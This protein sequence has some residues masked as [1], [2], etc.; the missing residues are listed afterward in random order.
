VIAAWDGWRGSIYRL[1]VTAAHRRSGL[2]RA[3]L[4]AAEQRLA[5]LGA[6]RLQATVVESHEAALGFWQTSGWYQQ[7]D[8]LRFVHG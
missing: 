7:T 5:E 4:L 2:G 8:R 3:L 1:A 6:A